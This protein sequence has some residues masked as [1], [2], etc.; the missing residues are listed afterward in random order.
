M[1]ACLSGMRMLDQPRGGADPASP[2]LS[3]GVY[4]Q[5]EESVRAAASGEYRE[6]DG[7]MEPFNTTYKKRAGGVRIKSWTTVY[8][9][10]Y[11]YFKYL[12]SSVAKPVNF[13]PR[14]KR[15]RIQKYSSL[16]IRDPDGFES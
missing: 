14:R 6:E 1:S 10:F 3:S 15:N 12:I 8:E 7:E 13:W 11:T 2:P 4:Q 5:E 9:E 16:L